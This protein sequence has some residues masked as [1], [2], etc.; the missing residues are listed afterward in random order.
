MH[1]PWFGGTP[2]ALTALILSVALAPILAFEISDWK[3]ILV[4]LS[5]NP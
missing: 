2:S 3:S 5:P 1:G 4:L